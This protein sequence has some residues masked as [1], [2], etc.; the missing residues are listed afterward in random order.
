MLC[1]NQVAFVVLALADVVGGVRA[2]SVGEV[3]LDVDFTAAAR[4][5]R[6]ELHSS[7]LGGQLTGAYSD[8]TDV[9]KPLHLWAARTHDWALG[10]PGQ[11]ICDWQNI[12]PLAHSD[13]SEAKNYFFG[14]TDEI[15][16]MTIEKL[17]LRVSYRMGTSI[18]SVNARRHAQTRPGYWNSREPADWEKFTDVH[19]H[20]IAHYTKGWADGRRWGDGIPYW[21]LWNE[22]DS[23]PGGSWLNADGSIDQPENEARFAKF[24]VFVLKKLKA[25]YPELKFGGPAACR[26]DE[27]FLRRILDECRKQDYVPDFLSWHSYSDDPDEMLAEPAKARALLDEYGFT[28]TETF[29]NE[30]HYIPGGWKGFWGRHGRG[31]ESARASQDPVWGT[32]GIASGVYTLQVICSLQTTV[33]DQS[34]YYGCFH[35]GE[36]D[37]AIRRLDGSLNK[38]YY[39]LKTFGM[40]LA[41]CD[42]FHPTAQKGLARTFAATSRDGKRRYLVLTDR[43]G[44]RAVNIRVKGVAEGNVW[45]RVLDATRDLGEI[46]A[47]VRDGALRIEKSDDAPAAYLMV[48]GD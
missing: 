32:G 37:Y 7:G 35:Y 25:D 11:R 28:K 4:P 10:N 3:D 1:R 22:A 19:R 9:L 16:A 36:F 27:P 31:L 40:V 2:G 34:Y 14:P 24:F 30:W 8:R 6:R 15:L 29:I 5:I 43:G 38:E 12:F 20:I 45:T 41:D 18:E 48:F 23:T 42:A 21:E 46:E 39:A 17:G 13:A 47:R 33:L 26:Y 44:K